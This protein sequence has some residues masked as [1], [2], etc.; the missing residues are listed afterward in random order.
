MEGVRYPEIQVKLV[1]EDGNAMAIL[2]RVR[3]G[4]K[5]AKIPQVEIEKFTKEAMAG[6]YN[7]LLTTVMAWVK[8]R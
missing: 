4:M 6:D 2:A 8:V 3:R 5:N 1:G 7:H